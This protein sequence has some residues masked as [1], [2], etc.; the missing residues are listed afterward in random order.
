[1]DVLSPFISVICHS[2]WLFHGKSCPRLDV[3]HPGRAWS[4]SPACNWH[5]SMHRLFLDR[6]LLVSSWCD[7][8]MLVSLL[9]QCVTIFFSS[10]SFSVLSANRCEDMLLHSFWV[11]FS[12]P[13]VATG[14]T[15]TFISCIFVEINMLWLFRIF[16]SDARIACPLFNL[17]RNSIIHSPSSEIGPVVGEHI[18]LL[19]LL[20]LNEYA[21]CYS[22][23]VRQSVPNVSVSL[24]TSYC[25]ATQC[26]L[27]GCLFAL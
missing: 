8:S 21:A 27:S 20:I 10:E 23:S 11:Q 19:H 3:V 6:Q 17:V 13:Y 4:S 24:I 1:M 7:Y 15:S 5:C 25:V 26:T 14:H 18:P 12:Q 22:I 9:W 16:C 2:D